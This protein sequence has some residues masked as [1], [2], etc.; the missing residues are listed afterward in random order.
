MRKCD[1]GFRRS[2]MIKLSKCSQKFQCS[3]ISPS[4]KDTAD[5]RR[6]F[7]KFGRFVRPAKTA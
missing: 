3:F 2:V 4:F 6:K 7:E 5:R 1:L